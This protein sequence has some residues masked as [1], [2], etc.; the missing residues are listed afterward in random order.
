MLNLSKR[1]GLLFFILTLSFV[2]FGQKTNKGIHIWN[3]TTEITLLF[4][5]IQKKSIGKIRAL[6]SVGINY[7]THLIGDSLLHVSLYS[8]FNKKKSWIAKKWDNDYTLRHEIGHFAIEEIYARL[9]RKEISETKLK[10]R[11]CLKKIKK[12]HTKYT[13]LAALEQKKYDDETGLSTN[14]TAQEKW[15]LMISNKLNELGNYKDPNL[16]VKF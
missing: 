5:K 6:S 13:N 11:N 16:Y 3:D 15:V 7:K 2:T 10:K 1:I 9:M 12:I 8:Y 4:F 14:E